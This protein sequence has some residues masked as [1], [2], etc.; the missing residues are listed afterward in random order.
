[1]KRPAI[2]AEAARSVLIEAGHRCAVCGVPCPLERAH[3]VPWRNSRDHAVENLICLCA[4][5]HEMADRDKWGERVLREYKA[6]P[7]VHRQN[8]NHK[9]ANTFALVQIV[10]Q[11]E[12]RDFDDYQLEILRYA[13]AKFLDTDPKAI[14]VVACRKGSVKLIIECPASAAEALRSAFQNKRQDL[15]SSL[16]LFPVENV[17]AVLSGEVAL[18]VIEGTP[19]EVELL[20]LVKEAVEKLPVHLRELI[21]L[22]FI[23]RSSSNEI[24]SQLQLSPDSYYRL[25]SHAFSALKKILQE[26]WHQRNEGESSQNPAPAADGRGRR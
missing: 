3:I 21:Y 22:E 25:K 11:K 12:L 8:S 14:K 20:D 10:I 13:L 17:E 16:P 2:P 9:E 18:A 26:M 15:Q 7:W 6:N 1:M 19:A 4:N 5:C 23:E 24:A